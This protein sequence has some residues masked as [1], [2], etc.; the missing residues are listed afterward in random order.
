MLSIEI[1]YLYVVLAA[2]QCTDDVWTST[3]LAPR[4]SLR[5][6]IMLRVIVRQSA[7]ER[8]RISAQ[9]WPGIGNGNSFWVERKVYGGSVGSKNTGGEGTGGGAFLI[10]GK[11]RFGLNSVKARA[12][13][14][15]R[16]RIGFRVRLWTG[17]WLG[18]NFRI[19]FCA[20]Y[21]ISNPF[22]VSAATME[23]VSPPEWRCR[24]SCFH[25][26]ILTS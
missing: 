26:H 14:Y 17:S 8:R 24:L 11:V 5:K 12:K 6:S 7:R 1:V 21:E 23:C 9:L 3:R 19:G 25:L 13:A 16:F 15:V 2:I 10:A 20:G 22:S 18:K 4:V